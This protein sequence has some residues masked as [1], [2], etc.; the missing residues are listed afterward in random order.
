M[1]GWVNGMTEG[2]MLVF[3][4]HHSYPGVSGLFQLESF[5]DL[6]LQRHNGSEKNI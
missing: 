5:L 2:D 3:D 1:F 6:C 4:C